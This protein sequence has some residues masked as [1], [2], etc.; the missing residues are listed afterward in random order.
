MVKDLGRYQATFELPFKYK[1]IKG[2]L[3]FN[4]PIL[5][6]PFSA[7]Y[8][9][10]LIEPEHMLVWTADMWDGTDYLNIQTREKE[11]F[12]SEKKLFKTDLDDFSKAELRIMRNEIY[13]RKGEIFTTPELKKYFDAQPWYKPKEGLYKL[14]DIEEHNVKLSKKLEKSRTK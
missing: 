4:T 3:T 5:N 11:A 10:Q 13:A 2:K 1:G 9:T 7:I 6:A 8:W 12:Y 14:T